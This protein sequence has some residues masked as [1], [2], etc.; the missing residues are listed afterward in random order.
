[1]KKMVYVL[2]GWLVF[3]VGCDVNQLEFDNVEL[4]TV[5]SLVAIPIGELSYTLRELID[6]LNGQNL[7]GVTVEE[8]PETTL[9]SLVYTD[10]VDYSAPDDEFVNIGDIT[11]S[12]TIPLPET[13]A[14]TADLL[15]DIP[16][17]SITLNFQDQ[18]SEGLDSI[19]YAGGTIQVNITTSNGLSVENFTLSIGNIKRGANS[20]TLTRAS[21]QQDLT[22]FN[23]VFTS[24]AD[25]NRY[26]VDLSDLQVLLPQGQ[27]ISTGETINITLTYSNQT[28]D[29]IFGYFGQDTITVGSINFKVDFFESLGG[30]NA[31]EFR[32][33]EINMN[34]TNSIG[35]PIGLK[36]NQVYGVS[37]DT[38][39]GQSDTTFL[40]GAAVTTPQ[41][42]SSPTVAQI[43]ESV[44]STVSLNR[45]NSTLNEIFGNTPNELNF[46]VSGIT[47]PFDVNATN[48]FDLNADNNLQAV[49][50][51]RL[52]M[53]MKL[54][55]LTREINL[56]I[57]SNFSVDEIDSAVLR[58]VTLNLLPFSTRMDVNFLDEND[59]V[60]YTVDQSLVMATPF[61]NINFVANE[62]EPNVADI[63]LSR[64]GI[65]ALTQA[66]KINLILTISTPETLNSRD[67]FPLWLARYNLDVKVSTLLKLNVGL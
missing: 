54:K 44:E 29:S 38:T 50:E 31:I 42:I 39:T 47:N 61:I 14:P 5:E 67:I 46:T 35:I 43:G 26:S 13:V 65:D 51:I 33:P 60:I 62:A 55:N 21:P 28:F 49:V 40:T 7:G 27:S 18:G 41:L 2:C 56:D 22:G 10:T 4:P 36:F 24:D 8:D 58:I 23:A 12:F 32:G 20:V 3:Q 25:S 11:N 34:F 19:V 30:N 57:N 64:E 66:K 17:Q 53:E 59:T 9:L 45:N 1:M 15:L 63:P 37:R 6:S 52:P 48:F 16:T